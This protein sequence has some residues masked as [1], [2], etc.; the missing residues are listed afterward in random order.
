MSLQVILHFLHIE[1]KKIFGFGDDEYGLIGDFSLETFPKPMSHYSNLE[2]EKFF[3]SK[4]G[5]YLITSKNFKLNS[6]KIKRYMDMGN[7]LIKVENLNSIKKLSK[8]M[9]WMKKE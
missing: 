1:D 5:H 6:K 8:F 3:V 9:D 4:R 7:S 2:I